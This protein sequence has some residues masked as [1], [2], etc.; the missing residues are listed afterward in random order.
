MVK[1]SEVERAGSYDAAD[2]TFAALQMLRVAA[3][4]LFATPR[5]VL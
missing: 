5:A 3:G 2:R 4:K 1:V